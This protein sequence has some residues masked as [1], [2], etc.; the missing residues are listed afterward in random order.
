M[1]KII[2]AV[3]DSIISPMY[4]SASYYF[5]CFE[6][7]FVVLPD[8]KTLIGCDGKSKQLQTEDI[9]KNQ[10]AVRIGSC[11]SYVNTV[12]FNQELGIL[13]AGYK[14]GKLIQYSKNFKS[15]WIQQKDYG[16]IQI[17][18]IF[19]SDQMGNYAVVGGH[20]A[21]KKNLKMINLKKQVVFQSQV[22][23][24]FNSVFSL[25]F[26]NLSQSKMFLSV[27]GSCPDYENG[28]TDIFDVSSFFKSPKTQNENQ[29]Y[30]SE[31][32]VGQIF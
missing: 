27:G 29:K 13:L 30:S 8:Q 10:F 22:Q 23:T 6:N 31:L 7:H 25:C 17:Q 18:E 16:D 32:N 19:S 5:V 14:N 26:A 11:T 21:N 9:T 24:S 2:N 3:G 28:K 20:A 4:K 15:K 1:K 12:L